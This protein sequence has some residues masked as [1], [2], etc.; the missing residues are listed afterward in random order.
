MIN[1]NGEHDLDENGTKSDKTW[2]KTDKS[3]FIHT[4]HV[5]LSDRWR[6]K[7]VL[8]V[9]LSDLKMEARRSHISTEAHQVALR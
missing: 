3:H 7:T 5:K 6:V 4:W 2:Q 1:I 9:K 8:Y